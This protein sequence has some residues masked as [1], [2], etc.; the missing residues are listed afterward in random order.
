MSFKAKNLQYG[1]IQ[2][3]PHCI[4]VPKLI[5]VAEMEEP[6]FL[7]RMRQGQSG[8]VQERYIA[9]RNKK[10]AVDDDEDA[11]VY[12]LE[13]QNEAISA[14]EFRELDSDKAK[15]PKDDENSES[16]QK[17]T[18]GTEDSQTEK[19]AEDVL[20]KAPATSE[21]I[22]EVGTK[23]NKRKAGRVVGVDEEDDNTKKDNNEPEKKQRL[24]KQKAKRKVKLSFGEEE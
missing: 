7:R 16:K 22:L 17:A 1:T 24:N 21:K 12:V 19:S 4:Q 18:D 14:K 5:E 15:D 9:P 3:N 2:E 23:V 6:A 8:D 20:R 10:Q 13:G 11:P